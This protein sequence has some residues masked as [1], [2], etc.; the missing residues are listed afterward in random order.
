[1]E[2]LPILTVLYIFSLII[3]GILVGLCSGLF[4]VGGGFLMVPLQFFLLTSNNIN[5]DIALIISFAT[6]LAIIIPTSITSAYKHNKELNNILKPGLLL[7]LFGIIGGLLGGFLAVRTPTKILQIIFGILLIIIAV[8]MFTDKNMKNNSKKHE[9]N[10][11]LEAIIGIF[12]GIF[13]GLLGVGGGVIIIPIL[14]VFI[15]YSLIESIGISSIFISLTAIGGMSSYIISG[16]N[17]SP[18]PYSLGYVNL[19]HFI[20]I[21]LFSIPF[22]YIGAYLSHKI[23]I[24]LIQKIFSILIILMAI[25]MLF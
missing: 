8:K 25:K 20:G 7:G 10:I 4:G 12:V 16:F 17:I 14:S 11:I 9:L 5:P 13:S 24:N 23:P 18:L 3:I 2:I 22:A 6:S 15:G 1:M 21:A 19:I